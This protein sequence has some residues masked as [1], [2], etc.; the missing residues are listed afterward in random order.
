MNRPASIL[1][2]LVLVIA[3]WLLIANAPALFGLDRIEAVVIV[4][5]Y[6]VVQFYGWYATKAWPDWSAA[7]HAAF[8][9]ALAVALIAILR[10]LRHS[11]SSL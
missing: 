10:L 7:K 5:I 9:I 6:V 3:L 2:D 8:G 1:I 11:A 4:V